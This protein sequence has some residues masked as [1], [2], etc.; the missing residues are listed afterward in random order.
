MNHAFLIKRLSRDIQSYYTSTRRRY[1]EIRTGRPSRYTPHPRWSE[2]RKLKGGNRGPCLWEMLAKVLTDR[3][4][5]PNAFIEFIFRQASL[6]RRTIAEGFWPAPNVLLNR[7]HQD[8]YLAEN[9]SG[10]RKQKLARIFAAQQRA[11]SNA[12]LSRTSL[13]PDKRRR[14][15]SVILD[16]NLPLSALFRYC[17][18]VDAD[19]RESAKKF[20]DAALVQLMSEY[21]LYEQ[22]WGSWIPGN[23]KQEVSL[24]V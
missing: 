11:A 22:V 14:I 16:R 10:K 2:G 9:N 20:H 6:D 1:E 3:Q 8:R 13:Y 5:S 21:E 18:A 12:L 24:S 23:L 19:M 17:L 7:E 15:Q 4:I